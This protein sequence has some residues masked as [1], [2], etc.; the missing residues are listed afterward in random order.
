M[1]THFCISSSICTVDFNFVRYVGVIFEFIMSSL[2]S[3]G[4]ITIYWPKRKSGPDF[5]SQVLYG[6]LTANFVRYGRTT[7]ELHSWTI[8]VVTWLGYNLQT[9]WKMRTKFGISSFTCT[10]DLKVF[11][12]YDKGNRKLMPRINTKWFIVILGKGFS[13]LV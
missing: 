9:K 13:F 5:L 10:F 2:W 12:N 4:L 6:V 11:R 1:R 7:K 8:M 3:C